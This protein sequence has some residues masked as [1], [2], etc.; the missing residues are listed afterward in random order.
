MSGFVDKLPCINAR[1]VHDFKAVAIRVSQFDDHIYFTALSRLDLLSVL[2]KRNVKK[3]RILE[4]RN[5]K[6]QCLSCL[7]QN[8]LIL[9]RFFI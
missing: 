6:A 3:A 8:N 9:E 7:L 5:L 1:K 4:H 2:D